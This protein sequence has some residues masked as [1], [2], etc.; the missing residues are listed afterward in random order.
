MEERNEGMAS[1]HAES[2]GA[3]GEISKP[4]EPRPNYVPGEGPLQCK[5]A[6][7]GE[8]PGDRER[9]MGRP[10]VG[11]AGGELDK[12]LLSAGIARGECYLT[13]V[14]K[15]Q[16]RP[17]NADI[18]KFI[19]AQSGRITQ[20]GL[21]HIEALKE[22]L[23]KCTAN[24]FV[25][26]GGTA[27]YALTGMQGITKWSGSILESSLFS[28]RKVI[29]T[30]HPSTLLGQKAVYLNRHL[31][32]A[33]LQRALEESAFPEIRLP[34]MQL[35]TRPSFY[36]A[37]AW[38]QRCLEEGLSGAVI[39]WDI[40][41]TWNQ[42][43]NCMAFAF[44]PHE[45]LCIPFMHGEGNYWNP[46]QEAE[47]WLMIASILED[48]RIQKRGQNLIFDSY[49][50]LVQHGIRC[51]NM[52]DCMIAQAVLYPDYKKGLDFIVR[53]HTKMPYY[54]DDRKQWWNVKDWTKH[55]EYNCKDTI[56][57]AL[58][59]PSQI[60][61][62]EQLRNV[63]TYL[64]QERLLEPLLFMQHRGVRIDYEGLTGA[65][66]SAAKQIE[67]LKNQLYAMCG[68]ELN[69]NSPAQMCNYF[70]V[71]KRIPPYVNKETKRPRCDDDALMRLAR[72]TQARAGLP[73]AQLIRD[74]RE[75]HTLHSRY[76][77]VDL[78][79][80]GRIR[81]AFNPVGAKT[82]RL[83]SGA[84][85]FDTGMNL[86]NLSPEVRSFLLFDEGYVGY[87]MDLS[88]AEN[89]L[90]AYCGPVP[91]MIECFERGEDVHSKTAGL[92]FSLDPAEI[93]R[94]DKEDIKCDTLAGG[95]YSHR[96]WG[97]KANHGLNYDEGPNTFSEKND[98]QLAEAKLIVN[99]YHQ[100][101]PGV[102]NG[103]HKMLRDM[104]S[105]SR[106]TVNPMGRVRLYLD[107][108]GDQLFRAAYNNF[109]QSTVA[110]VINERGLE[111]VYEDQDM[112]RPVELLLQVHDSIVFQIPLSIPWQHH[113]DI[114]CRIRRELELPLEWKGRSFVLPVDLSVSFHNIGKKSKSNP[115]GL[116]EVERS[117]MNDS[118]L[119]A[120]K[121]Q[122]MH[123]SFVG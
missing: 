37:K 61:Q 33:D 18:K 113:A 70:Y 104:L 71:K 2:C 106:T 32:V 66:D 107:R 79:P 67:S 69:I 47:L 122:E 30:F 58:A 48:P 119:L 51:T 91:E 74:I 92:M 55:W 81:C 72:G 75:I 40:E 115:T 120:D 16:P 3:F 41:T 29:G 99:R 36:D 65:R 45:S 13:N 25:A 39:D 73:E 26:L 22:E 82:G 4:H 83:S 98:I 123:S 111:F 15:E 62:L 38:L 19:D 6:F 35:H 56:A 121:L 87:N 59:H 109:A 110:D 96:Q 52:K 60:Q 93:K 20:L 7:V 5:I 108:W 86:Q 117:L 84:T 8:A 78:D 53:S 54:K 114:I 44:S 27:L 64:R 63:P 57:T 50:L 10:F 21:P 94:M 80:D 101:Y 90:V 43:V 88:Q 28:G 14:V 11:P 12:L 9:K 103:Y 24:V 102:K 34:A 31:I 85:V 17:S 68:E 112:F 95:R 1:V 116:A 77:T 97:K 42:Q 100:V 49:I 23:S 118:S 89:R 76:L 105:R 46:E